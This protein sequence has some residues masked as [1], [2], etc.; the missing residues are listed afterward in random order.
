METLN[1]P[2]IINGELIYPVKGEDVTV[3]QYDN[4]KII[5][6]IVTE[7]DLMKIQKEG[8][9]ITNELL[10]LTISDITEFLNK[11]AIEWDKLNTKGRKMAS[12]YAPMV[13]NYTDVII[14]GDYKTIADFLIQRFHI[15]D[16][17][18]AEFGNQRIFD[19]WI[20]S[21]MCYV[22]AFPRGLVLHYL[23]GNLPLVSMYSILRGI[24]TKNRNFAKIPSRDPITPI[25]LIQSIIEIDPN[26]PI[27]RSLSLGY[28]DHNDKI[29][30]EFIKNCN[31]INLWGGRNVM[32]NVKKKLP[33]NITIDE[34]GPKWSASVI[35]LTCCDMEKAAFRLIEDSAYYDQEACLNSQRAFV[36]G[37]IDIFIEYLK[38]YFQIFSKN[39]PYVNSNPDISANR[40]IS[41]SQAKYVGL[42]VEHGDDWAII[43]IDPQNIFEIQHPLAR[44]IFLHKIEDFKEIAEYFNNDSQTLG[45]FPWSLSEK[46]RD[47]WAAHGICRI[48]ELGWSR[49]FRAG[50]TLDGL[51]GMH[52]L[53]RIACIERPWTDSGRYYNYRENM[54][55]YWF[56]D[57]Y[58][59]YKVYIDSKIKPNL[60]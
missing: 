6:P 30:D 35:D 25:G 11:V 28:W 23:V 8:P 33:P 48:V 44:T 46:Y 49:I 18:E 43:V 19:E 39:V 24:I 20:P 40:S 37:D 55:Q 5:M 53:V 14:E 29:G 50:F 57:K 36:K 12:K 2:K 59:Q 4:L 54:E 1:L 34:Y 38:K 26:H 32:K 47:E 13:T 42:R 17:V 52:S 56:L 10:K 21:Q 45:V 22:K 3:L 51:R 60:D 31:S 41:L 15:Y 9:A 27:S 16:Q 7:S 58:P